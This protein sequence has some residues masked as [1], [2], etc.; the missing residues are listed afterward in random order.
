MKIIITIFLIGFSSFKSFSQ[1]ESGLYKGLERMC[2]TD[3]KGKHE[4]FD[5]PRKWYHENLLL[6][7]KDSFFIYKIPVQIVGKKKM[8]S[9]SDGAFYYYLGKIQKTDTGSI[10]NLIMN[11]CDYCGQRIK[12]DTATGFIFP[13]AEMESYKVRIIP[14]GMKIGNVSYYK[15]RGKNNYFPAKQMFYYDSNN[16]YRQ[17]PI[18]QYRLISTG[19]KNF[20][21][22]RELELDNDTLRISID[23]INHGSIIETLNP[24]KLKI[25]T[26]GIIFKFYTQK[27]LEN[28]TITL[29]RPVRYVEVREIIDYWKAATVS[30]KYV[31]SLP[32]TI[33]DF[34]ERQY[35]NLFKYNK[36]GTEYLLVDN[37]P[38][39]SW[40]LKEQK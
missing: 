5:A 4:C 29:N 10:V 12:I 7:D 40:G 25:D 1:V 23:R 16:I 22:T 18:G 37:L 14:K 17:D 2:W 34:S 9:A 24:E 39:N 32:K 8:Y 31:I 28:L 21:Q 33:H 36:V 19:I 11:N 3:D 20:L 30:F 13:L 35:N 26:S 38:E 15:E 27:E 6:I